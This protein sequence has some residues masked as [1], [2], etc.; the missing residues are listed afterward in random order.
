MR[1]KHQIIFLSIIVSLSIIS[2]SAIPNSF[3]AFEYTGDSSPDTISFGECRPPPP[4]FPNATRFINFEGNE[5]GIGT[6]EVDDYYK[7]LSCT[8]EDFISGALVQ[9]SSATIAV[10]DETEIS[11]GMFSGDVL[12]TDNIS[13]SDTPNPGW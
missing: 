8:V 5:G 11:S 2:V 10:L 1:D 3:A 13:F 6:I 12:I 4:A 7:N 9:P